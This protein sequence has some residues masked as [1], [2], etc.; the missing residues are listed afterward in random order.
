MY[1]LSIRNNNGL[2]LEE[3]RRKCPAVVATTAHTSRS[4]RYLYIST[5]DMI[6]MLAQAGFII[7]A[8]MQSRSRI[9]GK[10][11][12][13]RHLTNFRKASYQG[14][15][16]EETPEISIENSHDGTSG[17]R[18][19]V[20]IF[21]KVCLN[22]LIKYD[23]AQEPL[24]VMHRGG[25]DILRQLL[26]AT[27]QIAEE[28]EETMHTVAEMKQITLNSAEQLFFARHALVA[29]Y[30]EPENVVEGSLAPVLATPDQP[31]PLALLD[32][33]RREDRGDD[34]WRTLNRIQA[35]ILGN[36]RTK[37]QDGK[38]LR[39]IHSIPATVNINQYLWGVAEELKKFKLEGN[40]IPEA[41]QVFAY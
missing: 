24:N 1:D 4:Q 8:A 10:E 41:E 33:H 39:T 21:R 5:L 26:N 36:D 11:E 30:G 40:T 29:R 3:I 9:E 23:P 7:T 32:S 16:Y 20:V 18:L 19:R 25:T 6:E 12:H 28:A 14:N 27:Y 35:N 22:G 38:K 15:L 34:L 13:T 2:S 17:F 31:H 37:R